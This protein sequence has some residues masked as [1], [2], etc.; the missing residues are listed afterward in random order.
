MTIQY[1]KNHALYHC[2]YSDALGYEGLPD[3]V[4]SATRNGNGKVVKG[5]Q[6]EWFMWVRF[7]PPF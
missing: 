1:F 3:S 4:I 7:P 5:G 6:G 2:E